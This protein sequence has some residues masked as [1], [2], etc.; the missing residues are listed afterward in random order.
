M[1]VEV[2]REVQLAVRARDEYN[3]AIDFGE[4]G[5]E[6]TAALEA[7]TDTPSASTADEPE[8]DPA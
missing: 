4:L 3:E 8:S 7:G 6:M 2:P 5:A 1:R